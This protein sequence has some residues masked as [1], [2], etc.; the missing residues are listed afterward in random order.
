MKLTNSDSQTTVRTQKIPPRYS[1]IPSPAACD[2]HLKETRKKRGK[3]HG[4]MTLS[5]CQFVRAV[6]YKGRPRQVVN[7]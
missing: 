4:T 5:L 3:L 7:K 6:E 2:P 1:E